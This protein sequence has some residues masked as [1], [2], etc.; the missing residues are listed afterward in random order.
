M[1]RLQNHIVSMPRGSST[2]EAIDTL[3]AEKI[4]ITK[5]EASRKEDVELVLGKAKERITSQGQS[6]SALLAWQSSA[7]SDFDG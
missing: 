7:V 1:A 2:Q 5:C 4:D 3:K 6:L